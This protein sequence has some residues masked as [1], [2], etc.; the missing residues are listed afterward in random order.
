[1]KEINLTDQFRLALLSL[2]R[3][4]VRKIAETAIISGNHD[5][6]VERLVVPV[7]ERIGSDWENGKV[8]L[9]QVYM[10]GRILEELVD[11][12]LPPQSTLRKAQPRLAIAAL[13]DYHLLG[14]RIVYSVLRS[15][16]FGLKDY[17]RME[18]GDLVERAINDNIQVLL[19]SALMLA[20]ALHVKEVRNKFE[21]RGYPVKI[22]VGGAPF[23]LDTEL[24]KEVGAH[25]VG[26][27][28]SEAPGIIASF[29]GGRA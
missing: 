8:A 6:V 11:R 27:N 1:M 14:K 15:A 13:Q 21:A 29:M 4:A 3:L 2:D 18:A 5:N 20:S 26:R 19:I 17:G 22:V 7:M 24:W 23:R 12:F 25:A 9:S 10:S 16:G 28:A